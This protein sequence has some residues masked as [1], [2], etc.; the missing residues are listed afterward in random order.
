MTDKI[1]DDL[2]A[3]ATPIEDLILLPGNPR[4]G[5]VEAVKRSYEKFGQ[6][7]PIV[8]LLDGTVIAGNHQLMAARELGWTRI[9]VVRV[10]DDDQTAKAFALADNRT[11]DLGSY[12]NDAL[13]QLLQDVAGDGDLLIATGFNADDLNDLMIATQAPPSLSDLAGELDPEAIKA[14]TGAGDDRM[15]VVVVLSRETGEELKAYLSDMKDDE[16]AIRS[17]LDGR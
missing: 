6:R 13:L 17:L 3:L 2:S 5:D 11:G 1:A 14:A 15:S 16:A 12:D 9:A 8:A 7:K 10:D 4:K